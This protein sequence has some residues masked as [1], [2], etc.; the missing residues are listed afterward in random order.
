MTTQLPVSIL[1]R[2]EMRPNWTSPRSAEEGWRRAALRGAGGRVI[3]GTNFKATIMV[4]PVGQA[5]PPH[6]WSGEH[7]VFGIRGVVEFTIEGE[8]TELHPEDILFFPA[9]AVYEYRTVGA[10]D[11]SFLSIVGRVDEWPCTGHYVPP[12]NT[13]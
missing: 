1:R 11:A 13:A 4:I 8:S 10:Q 3:S 9:N 5:S 2:A 6:T 7:I 12:E